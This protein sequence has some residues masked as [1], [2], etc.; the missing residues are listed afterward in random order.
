MLTALVQVGRLVPGALA[1]QIKVGGVMVL[2][3]AADDGRQ[4]IWRIRREADGFKTDEICRAVFVPFLA[5][6]VAGQRKAP[7]SAQGAGG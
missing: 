4:R 5:G 3:L 2:P 6:A 7:A 1:D